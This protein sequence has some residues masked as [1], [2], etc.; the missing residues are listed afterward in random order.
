MDELVAARF[1]G[2]WF[3]SLIGPAVV[4]LFATFWHKKPILVTGIVIS[5]LLTYALCNIS[6]QEKW[7]KRMQ[8][9]QTH[10]EL[11]YATT[12]GANLVFTLFVLAPFEAILYT[13]VWGIVGWRI[14]PKYRTKK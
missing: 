3:L 13:S 1:N 6:V 11:A 10:E 2:Y 14:W 12:D 9:A 5:L 7:E 8:I 4:M